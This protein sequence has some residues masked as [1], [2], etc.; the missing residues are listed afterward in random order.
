MQGHGRGGLG[1]APA[2]APGLASGPSGHWWV[3]GGTHSL[4]DINAAAAAGMWVGATSAATHGYANAAELGA[5]ALK[6][7]AVPGT[8]FE[9]YGPCTNTTSMGFPLV[10]EEGV[11]DEDVVVEDL[12]GL[13]LLDMPP[14]VM[15]E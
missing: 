15:L 1:V 13:E 3:A 10:S 5:D 9:G 8:A 11:G 14:H 4:A 7:V 6:P 12:D 2:T